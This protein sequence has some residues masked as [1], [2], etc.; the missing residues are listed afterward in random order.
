[1]L[2]GEILGWKDDRPLPFADLQR[3]IGRKQLTK[4]I[5]A[6]VPVALVAFDVLELAGLDERE[7][8]LI[9]RRQALENCQL[10]GSRSRQHAAYFA[11]CG[12]QSVGRPGRL[13]AA[14]PRASRGRLHAQAARFTL[15]RGPS[16]EANG[17]SGKLSL[18]PWMRSSS[19]PTRQRQAGESLYGLHVRRLGQGQLVPFAKAYSGLRMR[20]FARWI[21]SSAAIRWKSLGQY[22]AL[23]QNWFSSWPLRTFRL[24]A[25]QV[26]H[27]RP[28]SAHRPL[29]QGQ[30]HRAGRLARY[31]LRDV[32]E[33]RAR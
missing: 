18:T 5:L 28:L 29:A 22:A 23:K 3:R 31:D 25:A 11:R 21:R 20:K 16:A 9:Q 17:G 30:A 19:M 1:M 26:G 32:A 6:E 33:A 14:E 2:D 4:R 8:P 15:C 13:A 12:R 27:C 24:D 7:T 10:R